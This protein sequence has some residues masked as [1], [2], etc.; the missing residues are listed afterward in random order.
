MCSAFP[1]GIP[2]ALLKGEQEHNIIFEKMCFAARK[3]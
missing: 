2:E 1:N 3:G